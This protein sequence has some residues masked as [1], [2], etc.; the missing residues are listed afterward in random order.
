MFR[1]ERTYAT[2]APPAFSERSKLEPRILQR[3]AAAA[4]ASLKVASEWLREGATTDGR[5]DTDKRGSLVAAVAD[6]GPCR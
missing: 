4:E 5:I 6:P 3:V 1:A 2:A